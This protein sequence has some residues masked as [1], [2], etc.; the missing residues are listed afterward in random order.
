MKNVTGAAR[1]MRI[2]LYL[3]PVLNPE[4][5]DGAGYEDGDHIVFLRPKMWRPEA[6][7]GQKWRTWEDLDDKRWI[8]LVEK[9]GGKE[10]EMEGW[11]LV[12]SSSAGFE[13]QRRM[14]KRMRVRTDLGVR[15]GR[16]KY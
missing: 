4:S 3:Q 2:V 9:K 10:G 7:K 5:Y 1:G 8:V 15:T 14:M 13:I 16:V 12:K 6:R 11:D